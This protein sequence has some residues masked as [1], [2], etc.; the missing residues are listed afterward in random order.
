MSCLSARVTESS[1]S[2]QC[3]TIGGLALTS[4]VVLGCSR[5]S[6]FLRLS[7]MKQT[8]EAYGDFLLLQRRMSKCRSEIRSLSIEERVDL[9]IV[10]VSSRAA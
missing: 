5:V 9:E 8:W 7:S 4:M 6:G 10:V 3:R 2:K 1:G